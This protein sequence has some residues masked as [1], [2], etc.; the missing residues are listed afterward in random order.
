MTISFTERGLFDFARS[1]G[2]ISMQSPVG[3]TERFIPPTTYL[4]FPA[5]GS[6]LPK[7]KSWVA[8]PD[9]ASGAAASAGV[10]FG[11]FTGDDPADLLASLTAV[12]SSVTRLGASTVRGVPVT[13]FAV[14]IDPAKA[15]LGGVDIPVMPQNP[16]DDGQWLVTAQVSGHWYVDIARSTAIFFGGTCP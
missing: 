10:P 7:G 8:L 13:G 15:K 12:S 4:K 6:T 5:T 2:T 1:R 9:G 3:M 16:G 14:K 11:P